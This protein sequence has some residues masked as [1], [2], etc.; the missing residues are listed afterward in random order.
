MAGTGNTGNRPGVLRKSGGKS[1]EEPPEKLSKVGSPGVGR[2]R[3]PGGPAG[4]RS[5]RKGISEGSRV[6]FD[7]DSDGNFKKN[8]ADTVF[9]D[10]NNSSNVRASSD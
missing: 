9:A 6:Q 5:N 8:L 7:L 1:G 10:D 4:G 2:S 3:S